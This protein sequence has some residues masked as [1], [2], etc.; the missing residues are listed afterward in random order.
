M[1]RT[2]TLDGGDVFVVTINPEGEWARSEF[3][4]PLVTLDYDRSGELIQIVAVGPEAKRLSDSLAQ[5]VVGG[6]RS[7]GSTDAAAEDVERA[8]APA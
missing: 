8:L 7:S 2:E 6:L 5:A 1:P 3:P 4:H